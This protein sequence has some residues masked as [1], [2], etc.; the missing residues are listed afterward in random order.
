MTAISLFF[1]GS[2]D[3][4]SNAIMQVGGGPGAGSLWR[5][6]RELAQDSLLT[7]SKSLLLAVLI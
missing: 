7:L 1:V 5:Y 4:A 3:E 2:F 6:C